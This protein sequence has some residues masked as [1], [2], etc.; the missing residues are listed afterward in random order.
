LDQRIIMKICLLLIIAF[1]LLQIGKAPAADISM[2]EWGLVSCGAKLSV[3]FTAGAN[4]FNAEQPLQL[5]IVIQNVSDDTI[6]ILETLPERDCVLA[7]T[8]P[9]G[10]ELSPKISYSNAADEEYRRIGI[11]LKPQQIYESKL[12]IRRLY[13]LKEGETY[14]IV[15]KRSTL[16]PG[17]KLC[18]LT[19]NSIDLTLAKPISS[20]E[21]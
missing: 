18:E 10:R 7:V 21:K 3:R 13:K 11:I 12:D 17:G 4:R 2:N 16:Q 9:S 8:S 15:V 14:K 20:P 5:A 6:T 19:S 1:G